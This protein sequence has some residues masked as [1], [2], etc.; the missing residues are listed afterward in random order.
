MLF[1]RLNR[2]ALKR[3]ATR[4]LALRF[5]CGVKRGGRSHLRNCPPLLALLL[6]GVA[7]LALPASAQAGPEIEV[8][9][10][11]YDFGEVQFGESPSVMIGIENI[12]DETLVVLEIRF[13]GGDGGDFS[14]VFAPSQPFILEPSQAEEIEIGYS[15]T[16]PPGPDSAILEIESNAETNPVFQVPLSGTGIPSD[17]DLSWHTID[18]GGEM[19]S[20]GGDFELSG[21][22]GQPDASTVVLAGGDFKLTGGFWTPAGRGPRFRGVAEP[23][24]RDPLDDDYRESEEEPLP[25]P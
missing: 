24:M 2:Q 18:G 19:F 9:P 7:A 6:V 25:P 15:P 20:T 17:K 5:A 13:Q 1:L 12:G 21:T 4:P 23:G 3:R 22:I 11:S 14:I 16:A 8:L 10:A